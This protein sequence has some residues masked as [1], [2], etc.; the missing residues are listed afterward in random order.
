VKVLIVH[1]NYR[2]GMPSGELRVVQRE[3]A[4]LLALG[5]QVDMFE[6]HSDDISEW[7]LARRAA[8]PVTAVWNRA[9][10]GSLLQRL[11]RDRPDIVHVHNTFPLLSSSVFSACTEAGVPVVATVHNYQIGCPT[12]GLFRD[13]HICTEC[14]EH[15]KARAL[16]HGCYHDSRLATLPV[17][18]SMSTMRNAWQRHVSALMFISARQQELLSGLAL[19][20]ERVF[21]KHNF[22]P[23]PVAVEVDAEHAV[24][25]LGRL[26][27]RKGARLLMSGWDAFRAG[28]P[29]SRL[30]LDIAGTG[31]L[32]DEVTRWAQRRADVRMLGLLDAE[33]C[34]RL[35][36]QSAAML[37]TSEWEEAFG[38]V[39]IEA[40]AC[41]AAP[42]AP[43]HGAFP[44]IITGGADGVLFHPGDPAAIAEVL[45]DVDRIPERFAALGRAAR[46]TYERRFTAA[47]GMAKLIEIYRFA[48][49]NPIGVSP[50]RS[51]VLKY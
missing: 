34:S 36:K 11:K 50:R 6:A 49:E 28:S 21:I 20:P 9:A 51:A 18:L 12:G 24:A 23:E 5:H 19:A 33:G 40:M 41:A 44:E 39:A 3:T 7:S 14:L 15:S 16:T 45:A 17:L 2:S 10:R 37:V 27:E 25:F 4:G 48:I 31:P 13:G 38:L 26:D 22:V 35:L 32:A 1:N 8:L 42:I 46:A 43:A 30:R 29:Q 47:F